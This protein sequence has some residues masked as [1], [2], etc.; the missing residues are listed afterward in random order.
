MQQR[1]FYSEPDIL[2]FEILCS[3]RIGEKKA[4]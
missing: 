4:I 3:D 2:Y 1:V